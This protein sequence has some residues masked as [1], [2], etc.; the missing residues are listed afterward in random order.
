M[1]KAC[2]SIFLLLALMLFATYN[3]VV[4]IFKG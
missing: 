1:K 4:R 3:D 2:L